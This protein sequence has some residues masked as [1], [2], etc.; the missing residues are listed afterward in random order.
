[1]GTL[2]NALGG[3]CVA[4]L[5]LAVVDVAVRLGFPRSDRLNENFS[6]T[7]LHR[8]IDALRGSSPTVV[9]GDS[10]LWGYGLPAQRSALSLLRRQGIPNENLSYEGGSPPNTYAML[11]ALLR[12]G[13]RPRLVVFNV[14]QKE[15]NPMDS[16]YRQLHPSVERLAWSA[17]DRSERALLKPT[18]PSGSDQALQRIVESTWQLYGMRN[19]LREWL[20]GDVDAVHVA[21]GAI[22]RIS[23]TAGRRRA[24]HR[25]TAEAFEGTYD[26]T[27]LNASDVSF[28]FLA[29]VADLLHRNRIPALA[30]L[31]PTNHVLLHQYVDTPEYAANLRASTF[32]LRSRGIEVLNL[33]D[34]FPGTDFIDNDHLN[35]AGNVRLAKVLRSALQ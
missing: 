8:E 33:D 17:L 10:A 34:A 21:Q 2:R 31:T 3:I 19:D 30:I 9:L 32:L 18:Q 5:L 24:A 13:V 35:A 7:Y 27:P 1:M 23:G 12:D 22:E 26:L 11:R 29:L 14:N 15:F 6:S 4:F 16:A 28:R 25:P 20:F